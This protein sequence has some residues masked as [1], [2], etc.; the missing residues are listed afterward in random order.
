MCLPARQDVRSCL[1]MCGF[2]YTHALLNPHIVLQSQLQSLLNQRLGVGDASTWGKAIPLFLNRQYSK[3]ES[4]N[5]RKF[6]TPKPVILSNAKIH[7][8]KCFKP[9]KLSRL[10]PPRLE[11]SI[12]K[13]SCVRNARLRGTHTRPR[14]C[15]ALNAPSRKV[16]VNVAH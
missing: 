5:T 14:Q 12:A 9:V 4:C 15:R 3:L 7:Y 10:L 2:R 13:H 16:H 11:S 8:P 1:L 6:T